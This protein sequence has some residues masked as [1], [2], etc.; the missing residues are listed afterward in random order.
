MPP[1]A[2]FEIASHTVLHTKN[3]FK[4]P[5]GNYTERYPA[6][7]PFSLGDR[8]DTGNPTLGGELKVSKELLLGSGIK[9]VQSFRSGELLYNP[10]LPQAMERLGYRYSSCFSAEDVLSYFPYRYI[11][12][13]SDLS[14]ESPIWELP[15]VYEDEAFPPLYFRT[16]E[17]LELQ[18]KIHEN[19]GVFTMLIHPDLTRS[20]L[21]NLD[22]S[23]LESFVKGLPKEVWID[24]MGHV[25]EFWDRRD[26]I[27]F[28][29]ETTAKSIILTIYSAESIKGV[30]FDLHHLG[31][32]THGVPSA[33]LS[34]DRLILDISKGVSRWEFNRL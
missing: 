29:Y 16:D 23:F 19:G 26:R 9:S 4:L 6:Y 22:L 20:R 7:R 1:N 28:R 33:R 5:E 31:L 32:D 14:G 15:L 34:G 12:N 3:F 21:K 11:R 30:G 18:K 25:G 2:G 8:K 27:V 24:T 10:K 17:A 13:Y